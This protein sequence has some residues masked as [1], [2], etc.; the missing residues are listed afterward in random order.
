LAQFFDAD[1]SGTID[2]DEFKAAIRLKCMVRHG[3]VITSPRLASSA[4]S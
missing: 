2:A 4:L 1:G 3:G